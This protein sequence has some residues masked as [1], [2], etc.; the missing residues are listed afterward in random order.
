[1]RRGGAWQGR[2]AAAR[3]LSTGFGTPRLPPRARRPP[4]S[5]EP[6]CAGTAQEADGGA[7]GGGRVPPAG[8]GCG[9]GSQCARAPPRDPALGAPPRRARSTAGTARQRRRPPKTPRRGWK[10]ASRRAVAAAACLHLSP[11]RWARQ[12]RR[13]GMGREK[14]ARKRKEM[15]LRT[16]GILIRSHLLQLGLRPR[17]Q[18]TWRSRLA[19]Y[20]EK[21]AS[22]TCV[23]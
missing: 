19:K 15:G 23:T 20:L 13:C 11:P 6:P 4:P 17:F 1:M 5:P 16:T 18:P 14:M 22:S 7:G 3:T 8:R 10:E 12:E 21:T 9:R 2:R